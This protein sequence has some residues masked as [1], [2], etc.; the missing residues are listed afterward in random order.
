MVVEDSFPKEKG[1]RKMNG[2]FMTQCSFCSMPDVKLVIGP[3]VSIC[4]KCVEL[5]CRTFGMVMVDMSKSFAVLVKN[6]EGEDVG[7]KVCPVKE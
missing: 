1:E 2:C 3:K 6:A 4:Q 7:V 5:A